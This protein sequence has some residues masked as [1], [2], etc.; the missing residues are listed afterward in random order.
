[1]KSDRTIHRPRRFLPGRLMYKRLR[2]SVAVA[3][4]AA[5]IP[6]FTVA[7]PVASASVAFGTCTGTGDALSVLGGGKCINTDASG[8]ATYP[9]SGFIFI[10]ATTTSF[11]DVYTYHIPSQGGCWTPISGT[12]SLTLTPV[13]GAGHTFTETVDP[14]TACPANDSALPAVTPIDLGSFLTLGQAFSYTITIAGAPSS[15]PSGINSS[16]NQAYWL[17]DGVYG[18]NNAKTISVMFAGPD[19]PTPSPVVTSPSPVVTSPS[20]VVT[21]PSPALTSP[22]PLPASPS[23]VVT[24]PSPVVTSPSPVVTSPS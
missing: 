12:Y 21:S 20:P 3:M 15:L 19:S 13:L 7:R 9:Y 11:V 8:G 14:G 16:R 5:P 17:V 22:S 23:P 2:V 6:I 4:L 10:P 24:S 1:M 18:N